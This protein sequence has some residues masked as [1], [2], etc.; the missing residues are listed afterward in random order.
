MGRKVVFLPK[1]DCP[2]PP[3]R[4]E[5]EGRDSRAVEKVRKHEGGEGSPWTAGTKLE[6]GKGAF[7]FY[8]KEKNAPCE[9]KG[10]DVADG[11]GEKDEQGEGER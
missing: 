6:T 7:A 8:G 10:T 4:R 11:H 3:I 9:L 1:G 2:P 5:R